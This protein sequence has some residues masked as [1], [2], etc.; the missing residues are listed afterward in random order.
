MVTAAKVLSDLEPLFRE[1]LEIP[2]LV[3]SDILCAREVEAWDSLNHVRIISAAEQYF[4]VRL[5]AS[6][7]ER[8][9]N[10]GDLAA[11]IASKIKA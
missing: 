4:A 9:S 1:I 3:V 2:D 10:A 5:S 11:L 6:E 7:I 8:L